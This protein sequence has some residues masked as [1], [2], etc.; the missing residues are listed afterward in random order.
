[1]KSFV[2][3]L[4]RAP[5]PWHAVQESA[6]LLKKGGFER[7]EEAKSWSLKKGGRYFVIHSNGNLLSA[8]CLPKDKPTSCRLMGSHLDSPG[9][10][11]RPKP[12][13]L[14]E[15]MA[16]VGVEVYGGPLL[17]SWLNRDLALAGRILFLTKKGE[18]ETKLVHFRDAPLVIPQLAIHLDRKID[19]EGLKLNKQD[20]LPALAALSPHLK[21]E[22]G[23]VEALLQ[24]ASR[25][26][27]VLGFELFLVP[28]EPPA[29]IG[30]R[31]EILASYR[32]D[33]LSSFYASLEALLQVKEPHPN[34]IQ[35]LC[36]WDHEEIGSRTAEGAESPFL[37]RILERITLSL[38]MDREAYLQ[39]LPASL[40]LS[41]DVAHG[42][43]P[44][45]ADRYEPQHKLILGQGVVLKSN[46][47]QRH[48][49]NVQTSGLITHL[50]E[51]AKVK[52]QRAADRG[53]YPSGSTIGPV[54][55]AVTGMATLDL[56][57]PL[58]SMHSARELISPDDLKS[59]TKLLVAFLKEKRF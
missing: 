49:S 21:K 2:E 43:H 51:K 34:A 28:T 57:C 37:A 42:W 25:G 7:L 48:L 23:Y 36:S 39:L 26:L 40:C 50:A 11:V 38:S 20:N 31:G 59:L 30:S 32:L 13:Q 33:N 6:D 56:G 3:F 54:H 41:L 5:T 45:Y 17:S 35:M 4:R 27:P 10:K 1:M 47:G 29:L 12:D 52:I 22:E 14:K 15:G 46:A 8:F 24:E 44:N 58:L 18:R 53:D 9:L 16:M 55:A 19:T